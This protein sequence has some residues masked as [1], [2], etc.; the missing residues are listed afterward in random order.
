MSAVSKL[1]KYPEL[2]EYFI[3]GFPLVLQ[4]ILT[5]IVY[6]EHKENRIYKLFLLI[7]IIYTLVCGV[8]ALYDIYFTASNVLLAEMGALFAAQML[9]QLLLSLILFICLLIN[10]VN[11]KVA[12]EA[13]LMPLISIGLFFLGAILGQIEVSLYFLL[14][15]PAIFGI[16][17]PVLLYILSYTAKGKLFVKEEVI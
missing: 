8:L 15:I 12:M 17:N 5:Y 2:Y 6:R 13:I 3:M 1:M 7:G 10:K 16:F 14:S 9:Y 11:Q 4:L